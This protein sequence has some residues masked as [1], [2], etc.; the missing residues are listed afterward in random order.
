[1]FWYSIPRG[2]RGTL[3][4]PFQP[5]TFH[6]GTHPPCRVRES[7]PSLKNSLSDG[8]SIGGIGVWVKGKTSQQRAVLDN[9]VDRVLANES[10]AGQVE[11]NWME[12]RWEV[13]PVA[14]GLADCQKFN[15]K[16]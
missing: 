12:P 16:V 6:T 7:T 8:R 1:M 2:S 13:N 15:S 9:R 5:F 14:Q 4:N 10:R 3:S 11:G